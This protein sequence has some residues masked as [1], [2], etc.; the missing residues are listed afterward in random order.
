MS[1]E[2]EQMSAA[3]DGLGLSQGDQP[4]PI[5]E[6]E[7]IVEDVIEPI[8]EPADEPAPPKGFMGYNEWIEAGKDPADFKGENAYKKEYDHIQDS[9]ASKSEIKELRESMKQ[10]VQATQGMQ[11]DA[12]QRGLDSRE[13]KLKEAIDDGD[14]EAVIAAKDSIA[15]HQ[16][17]KPAAQAAQ[18]QTNPVHEQFF[19]D[20]PMLDQH[21]GSFDKDMMAEFAQIYHGRLE[22]NGIGPNTQVSERA[23]KGYMN[24]ALKATK[25]LFP[26]KFESP[27]NARSN[28]SKTS[29]R[30]TSTT[31]TASEEMKGTKITTKNPR[32]TTAYDDVVKM[33]RSQAEKAGGKEAGDAAVERFAKNMRG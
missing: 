33:I 8:E 12:Y 21:S 13:L 7:A 32:D 16:D 1:S 28:S 2:A 3:L 31:K 4:A 20:N 5:K 25:E 6:P 10:V 24:A 23:M 19:G 27:R 15:E 29:G 9:K 18:P 14:V 22:A 26:D 17:R 30:R 11:D